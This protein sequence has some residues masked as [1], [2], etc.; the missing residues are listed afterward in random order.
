MTDAH[1]PIGAGGT[2][3]VVVAPDKF[4]GSLS[5]AEVAEHVAA[6]LRAGA[7]A[8][9][10]VDCVPVADGGEGTLDAMLAAGFERQGVTAK[11]PTGDTVEAAYGRNGRTAAVELASVCGLGLLPGG[12][13]DPLGCSSFGFGQVVAAALGAGCDEIVLG[14]GGSAS[15]DG[16]AGML[17]A[18]GVRLL[19]RSG[20]ALAANGGTLA[21]VASFDLGGL[22]PAVVKARFVVACDVDNPLYGPDG[23]A[24]VYG[25]QKGA[26]PADV[27][28]LDAGLRRWAD[29]VAAATG[30]DLAADPGAGAAG[31]VGFAALTFL[32]A[33]MRPGIEIVLDLVGIERH[34]RGAGLVVTGEGAIDEQTLHGKAVAGVATAARSAGVPT[35]AVAGR[36]LLTPAR[37]AEAGIVAAYAL[38]DLEADPSTSVR[39]A[40]RLLERRAKSIADD[41]LA[42]PNPGQ[43]G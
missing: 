27:L 6:G 4:K 37:L 39:D 15:T 21:D 23:A 12:R 41:W 24:V 40:G 14:I 10:R 5:A 11:G 29:V 38:S 17:Q 31:G 43:S 28:S 32:G 34:L 42:G 19:D 13:R 35:V 2:G 16:G 30:R 22:H 18:L 8:G 9:L 1:G 36:V 25:P 3:H 26:S 20:A 33:T 7:R